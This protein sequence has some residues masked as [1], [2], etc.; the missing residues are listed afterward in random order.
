MKEEIY[1]IP[2]MD[3]FNQDTECPFCAMRQ[4]IEQDT[5]AY[6]LSPSYMEEDVRGE[7]N[8]KGFCRLHMQMLYQQGNAL[9][10]S[11]ML[12]S[13]LIHQQAEM[14]K[15]LKKASGKTGLFQKKPQ[16]LSSL[17]AFRQKYAASCYV[18]ERMEDTI[19]QRYL[20]AFFMLYKK[21]AAFREKVQGCKGFCLDHFMQIYEKAA[22]HLKAAD[23]EPFRSLIAELELK[24]LKRVEDDL[25]WFS[26]KFDY[27]YQNEPWK[28]SRDAL[29]R[30]ILKLRS[31]Y[32]EK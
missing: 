2:V 31:F 14:E 12:H 30:S 17:E 6:V 11:L 24:H 27:Q 15:N 25:E 8:E 16:T 5:I 7:T 3:G 23:L 22:L 32:P 18:C 20:E 9:G 13:Q 21:E 4:K 1:T 19:F 26:K 28:E 10:L 29:P